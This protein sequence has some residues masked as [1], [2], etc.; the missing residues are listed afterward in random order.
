MPALR[1]V[2]LPPLKLLLAPLVGNSPSRSLDD[3]MVN[4]EQ[5][6]TTLDFGS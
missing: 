3:D 4:V 1:T 6:P 5:P 2:L